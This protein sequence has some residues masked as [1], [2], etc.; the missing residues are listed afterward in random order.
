MML[1]DV[2]VEMESTA[3]STFDDYVQ[4]FERLFVIDDMEA[5]C[6]AIRSKSMI[7]TGKKRCLVDPSIAVALLG[8]SP[9][10]LELDLNTFG[11]IFE[12]LSFR[13]LK[14]YSQALGGRLS[15]YHDRMGLEADAVLHL[16]DGRYALIECKLGSQEIEDAAEHLVELKSLIQKANEKGDQP[17]L[18]LPD[19]LIVLTGGEM[20][21]TRTDGVKI[22]PIGCLKD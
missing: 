7:R 14:V 16:D 13:D 18:R 11:F 10:T 15:Y 5:W 19:L 3:M 1:A 2:S 6:P 4:A 21:Y 12:C 17:K 22:I 8:A 20:A 9:E